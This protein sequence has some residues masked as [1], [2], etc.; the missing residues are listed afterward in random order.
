MSEFEVAGRKID[1]M[2]E[3]AKILGET[4]EEEYD[5][6]SGLTPLEREIL[7]VLIVEADEEREVRRSISNEVKIVSLDDL[8]Y[9]YAAKLLDVRLNDHPV[10]RRALDLGPE[11]KAVARV[12]ILIEEGLGILERARWNPL[13]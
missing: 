11:A 6:P 2:I 1:Q 3:L 4:M 12:C 5:W 13:V 8:N 10:F 7:V 9:E